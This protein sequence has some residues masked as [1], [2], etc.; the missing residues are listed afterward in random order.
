MSGPS[1]RHRVLPGFA[2][3]LGLSMTYLGAIVLL[4]LAGLG[5]FAARLDAAEFWRVVTAPRALAAYRVSF[6][7]A[8]VAA[9]LN[10]V[11][12]FIVAWVLVRYRFPGR[13]IVDALVDLPFALPTAVSG[14]ALTTLWASTG[15]FGRVLARA[16]VSVAFTTLG[17]VVALTLI[18]LPF[19]VRTLQP[20]LAE[21]EAEVEEAAASLGASRWQTFVRVSL[22]TLAPALLTG[23]AMAFAR[24][25]GEYGSVVFIAGNM[26]MR[27][28]IAPL[29][30][31]IKLEQFDYAG[32]AALAVVLL[33]VSS[34]MLLA[35][36][37]LQWWSARRWGRDG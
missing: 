3:T 5:A 36:N 37:G 18:G 4:P 34:A 9:A 31:L 21:L 14:I 8:A 7:S 6:G 33:A 15:W 13:R 10:A 17:I 30:I 2:L 11:F 32:A 12:G 27:T 22:P 16:G 23:V 19:V 24:A 29:L 20:A 35:I 28:E 25:V 26:P 1:R